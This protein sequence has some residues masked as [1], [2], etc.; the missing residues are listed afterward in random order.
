M[1]QSTG[2]GNRREQPERLA[3]R[4]TM[5]KQK[6][7]AVI[8]DMD[9]V[10]IDS[11]REYLLLLEQ[12]LKANGAAVKREEL[13]VLTGATRMDEDRFIA[14]KLHLPLEE[15]VMKK[16]HFYDQRPI[17]YR[18]IRKE[19]V[20][21]VL[22]LFKQ[23]NIQIALASSSPMDNIREVLAAC[24]IES[25]FTQ[26]ISGEMFK[27]TKP[28]P[29]IYEYS[30]AKLGVDKAEILVVEDSPY[31]IEAAKRAGLTVVALWDPFFH[32]DVSPADAVI[33]SLKELPAF[34]I[35]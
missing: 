9:G 24:E 4:Q 21:E 1:T 17:D 28:D 11:E 2:L 33:T 22:A 5:N 3:E 20:P 18:A 34:V 26:Y 35:D 12:F 10:L 15:A 27:R 25:Y 16:Q 6:V 32:F 29:E 8:F 14:R 31:G 7:Q 30:V 23:H 13:F 19:Y